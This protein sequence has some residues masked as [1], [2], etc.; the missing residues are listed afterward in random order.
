MPAFCKSISLRNNVGTGL[1]PP[2]LLGTLF[3]RMMP[4]AMEKLKQDGQRP[5]GR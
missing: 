3:A 5:P 4:D 2:A 1:I